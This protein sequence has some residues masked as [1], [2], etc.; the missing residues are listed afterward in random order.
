MSDTTSSAPLSSLLET[1][2]RD[3]NMWW[4]G[5]RI[6]GLPPMRRWA[7]QPVMRGVRQG[8]T[9]ITVVRG[10][11]QIGKTTLLNQVIDALIGEGISPRRIFRVQFDEL[12]ELARLSEPI[13]E[14][15]R[16]YADKILGKSFNQAAHDG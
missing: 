1:T 7:F 3:D 9:P 12:P 8:M 5:E 11:R 15:S 6:F 2:L 16:W 4:R 10:P 13:L 14:L